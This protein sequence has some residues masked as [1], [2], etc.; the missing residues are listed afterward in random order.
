M[1][2]ISSTMYNAADYHPSSQ[3]QNGIRAPTT[4]LHHESNGVGEC[5]SLAGRLRERE[6]KSI[7]EQ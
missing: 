3:E 1:R 7:I 6:A 4:G 5:V 2:E